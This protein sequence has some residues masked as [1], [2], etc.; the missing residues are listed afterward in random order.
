[1]DDIF[2]DQQLFSAARRGLKQLSAD[3]KSQLKASLEAQI[4]ADGSFAGAKNESDIY[5][6]SFGFALETLL[7]IDA[8]GAESTKYLQAKDHGENLDFLHI[9]SLARSWKFFAHDSLDAEL[10]EKIGEKLEYN[11]TKDQAWNQATGTHFG[12]VYGTYLA[13]SAYQNLDLSVPDEIKA[14]SALKELKSRDG[15]FGTDRDADHGSTP[16]TAMAVLLLTYFEE[17]SDYFVDWLMKQQHGDGGF[18]AVAQ[19]PFSDTQSTVYTLFALK[20]AAPAEFDKV[21]EEAG[22]FLLS[23]KKET[24]FAGHCR[25]T[26]TNPENTFFA[27]AGLGLVNS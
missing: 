17:S 2:F 13:I 6:S 21:K 22:K 25:D 9:A 3:E 14:L 15:A 20:V 27:L 18:R 26:E 12:S 1:M 5:M 19:M 4:L 24:G 16:A 10:Y 7:H 11:R 23:M 8:K